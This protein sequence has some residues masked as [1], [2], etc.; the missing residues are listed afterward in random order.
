M[1]IMRAYPGFKKKSHKRKIPVFGIERKG[2]IRYNKKAYEK[3]KSDKK[4]GQWKRSKLKQV[5]QQVH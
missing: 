2:N 5:Y 3:L 4:H 1:F